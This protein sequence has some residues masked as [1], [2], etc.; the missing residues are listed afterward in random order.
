VSEALTETIDV[1]PTLLEAAGREPSRRAFGQS[2]T[3]WLRGEP[4]EHREAVFS[5]VNHIT[6]VRTERHKYAMDADGDGFMLY[7]LAADP[8]ERNNLIGHPDCAELERELRE[9]ILRWLASTQC[10]QRWATSEDI[11][12]R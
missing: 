11:L 12:G 6:M 8:D 3:P 9:R 1:F 7:D 2:L 5:E 10:R 4:A